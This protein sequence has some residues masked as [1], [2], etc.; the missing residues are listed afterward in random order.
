MNTYLDTDSLRRQANTVVRLTVVTIASLIGT[1]STG[2]LGMNLIDEAAESPLVR[3]PADSRAHG[4]GLA[5]A[6][7]LH[8]RALQEPVGLSRRAVGRAA[9]TVG[10]KL[11]L[12]SEPG[13]GRGR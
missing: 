10:Q 8:D 1:L 12:R 4:A 13:G 6:D 2:F 5:A 9:V 11:G 7:R 3:A